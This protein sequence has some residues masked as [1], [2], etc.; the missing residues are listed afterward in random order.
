M[1]KLNQL[2]TKWRQWINRNKT[3]SNDELNELENH[4]LEEIDDLQKTEGLS[5]EDAFQKVVKVIG[6][7]EMLDKEFNKVRIFSL[8]RIVRWIQRYSLIFICSLF[9]IIVILLSDFWF[10]NRYYITEIKKDYTYGAPICRVNSGNFNE[11]IGQNA[12]TRIKT[13]KGIIPNNFKWG[14]TSSPILTK[15]KYWGTWSPYGG[16]T[17]Y[18]VLDDKDQIW[19]DLD[20][21]FQDSSCFMT[22]LNLSSFISPTWFMSEKVYLAKY[23]NYPY[24]IGF[25][26][27]KDESKE[28]NTIGPFPINSIIGIDTSNKLDSVFI[29]ESLPRIRNYFIQ[30]IINKNEPWLY[31]SEIYQIQKPFHILSISGI[32]LPTV[33]NRFIN[34][35]LREKG[36]LIYDKS[37]RYE[38]RSK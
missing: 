22:T 30:I 38:F 36:N 33:I 31:F 12:K 17:Y 18:I 3:F 5:E 32:K 21:N 10:S 8:K 23:K 28:N 15:P 25:S 14:S 2:V 20:N 37:N 29:K 9:L 1:L 6:G 7:R 11:I 13:L 27:R 19:F 4:L 24:N 34:K 26:T 35:Q 16:I